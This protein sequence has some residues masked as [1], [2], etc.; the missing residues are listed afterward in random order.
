MLRVLGSQPGTSHWESNLKSGIWSQSE[1]LC[2][3]ILCRVHSATLDCT[4]PS[5]GFRSWKSS[6]Q[7]PTRTPTSGDLSAHQSLPASG[8]SKSGSNVEQTGSPHQPSPGRCGRPCS[9]DWNAAI[10]VGRVS[11]RK[12]LPASER[13]CQT[14]TPLP[15][16]TGQIRQPTINKPMTL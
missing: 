16:S 5:Q 1:H 10:V 2:R 4:D 11:P 9:M 12:T 7:T 8:N 6:G 15:R 14:C 3:Y 13:F